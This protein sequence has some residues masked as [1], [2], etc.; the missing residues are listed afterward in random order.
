MREWKFDGRMVD[1][2]LRV[3]GWKF[4]GRVE[5]DGQRPLEGVAVWP[6]CKPGDTTYPRK[7]GSRPGRGRGSGSRWATLKSLLRT[8]PFAVDR[9]TKTW[10]HTDKLKPQ[11]NTPH[12]ESYRTSDLGRTSRDGHKGESQ[13]P[14]NFLLT[15]SRKRGILTLSV[16]QAPV[17]RSGFVPVWWFFFQTDSPTKT[18]NC[19]PLQA[20][21][22][23]RK[24]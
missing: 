6:G 15:A 18:W 17:K 3:E 10:Y 11:H 2:A 9:T 7:K 8:F 4:G 19:Q 20:Q 21:E 23:Q 14:Q 5:R 13:S 24:L 22:P 12:G 16:R 1:I